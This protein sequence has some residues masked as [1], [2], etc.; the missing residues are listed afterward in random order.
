[1]TAGF[2]AHVVAALG[3]YDVAIPRDGKYHHPLAAVYATRL[4]T[5]ARELVAA[6]RRRP[7]FLIEHSRAREIDVAEIRQVDPELQSLIN[8]NTP[9]DYAVALRDAGFN[10]D[11]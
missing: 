4:A 6:G 1:L 3:E 7:V 8:I 2:V 11:A 10:A 5:A 9:A